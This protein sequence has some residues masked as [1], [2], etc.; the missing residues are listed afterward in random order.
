MPAATLVENQFQKLIDTSNEPDRSQT[1]KDGRQLLYLLLVGFASYYNYKFAGTFAKDFGCETMQLGDNAAEV[2]SEICAMINFLANMAI[3][4]KSLDG[5]DQLFE[6]FI[7]GRKIVKRK[8]GQKKLFKAVAAMSLVAP[9]PPIDLTLDSTQNWNWFLKV[10][11]LITVYITQA[12]Q[13]FRGISNWQDVESDTKKAAVRIRLKLLRQYNEILPESEKSNEQQLMRLA[14]GELYERPH[15]KIQKVVCK[16][17]SHIMVGPYVGAAYVAADSAIPT[18]I[19]IFSYFGIDLSLDKYKALLDGLTTLRGGAAIIASLCKQF[20]LASAAEKVA[21]Y[22]WDRFFNRYI[23]P[24][25]INATTNGLKPGI[26]TSTFVVS[27]VL[28]FFSVM[29]AAGVVKDKFQFDNLTSIVMG[30]FGAYFINS[31]DTFNVLISWL[32]TL[33]IDLPGK[34]FNTTPKINKDYGKNCQEFIY[35]QMYQ[36]SQTPAAKII[37][38][39]TDPT[40]TKTTA[41]LNSGD[42]EVLHGEPQPIYVIGGKKFCSIQDTC[43]TISQL[44]DA[45]KTEEFNKLIE[46]EETKPGKYHQLLLKYRNGKSPSGSWSSFFPWCTLEKIPDEENPL[47]GKKQTN[48]YNSIQTEETKY[49]CPTCTIS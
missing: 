35:K 24:D 16:T 39:Y 15:E 49:T 21:N 45:Q 1:M 11:T 22:A 43:D 29:G 19:A 14:R 34:L 37:R 32:N 4:K 2:F 27:F 41:D 40:Q 38:E 12:A 48:G 13:S 25:G 42:D 36:I 26:T 10:F 44:T 3:N 47:L 9:L 17:V 30:A 20:L 28:N 18:I 31:N 46:N 6:E 33:G 7:K 23:I 8:P 5:V